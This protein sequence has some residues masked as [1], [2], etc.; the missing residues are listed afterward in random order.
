MNLPVLNF[1]T[2][3]ANKLKE[4]NAKCAGVLEIAQIDIDL[5]EF[6]GTAEEVSIQKCKTAF[7]RL[8]RP[9]LIEDTS[10]CF[11]AY[12]G[13]P[14]PYIKW[15]LT[16]LTVPG[17]PR[18]LDGF[19]DKTGYAQCIFAYMEKEDQEPILFV[20]QTAGTIVEP[21]GKSFGWDPIFQPEG[22]ETTFGEME[23][24]QKNEI[25]H[26]GKA[27]QKLI[28]HFAKQSSKEEE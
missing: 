8:K 24:E 11:N 15:F 23:L 16:N 17:L 18:M 20:G 6:Q 4:L 2:G 27:V 19:E 14:G 21:R 5:P 28:D 26:R 22:F 1:V 7:E 9:V 10:L 12:K 13:L 25:S 3:N